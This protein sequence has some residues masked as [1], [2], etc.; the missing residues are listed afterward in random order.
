MSR[1]RYEVGQIIR[2]YSGDFFARFQTVGQVHK[3]FAR[4]ALCRTRYLGGHVEVSTDD[5]ASGHKNIV[6]PV[7]NMLQCNIFAME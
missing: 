7:Q 6:H 4:M 1:T 3:S 5:L 2:D